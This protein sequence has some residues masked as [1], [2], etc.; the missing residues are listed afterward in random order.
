MYS[1][2]FLF[3]LITLRVMF[4]GVTFIRFNPIRRTLVLTWIV[5]LTLSLSFTF[6]DFGYKSS[7]LKV[8]LY[9]LWA[10]AVIS[11]S[12]VTH[13]IVHVFGELKEILGIR[14]FRIN[15]KVSTN[16]TPKTE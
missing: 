10:L 2:G 5:I 7:Q 6:Y 11:L 1:F 16:V 14:M 9:I 13:L 4:S 15:P 12:S 3:V 8:I